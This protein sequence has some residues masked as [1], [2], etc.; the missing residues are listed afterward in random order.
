MK[1]NDNMIKVRFEL[2]DEVGNHFTQESQFEVFQSMGETA[3]D[4]IGAKLN[5][6]LKQAGYYRKND[7][8][9]MEDLTDEEYDAVSEFL[10]SFRE[11]K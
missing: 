1:E 10:R 6:F 2:T 5:V 3:V 7:N 8:I 11:G 9:L 4:C